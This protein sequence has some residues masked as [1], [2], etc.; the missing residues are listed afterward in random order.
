MDKLILGDGLLGS[1]LVKQTNWDYISR[2]KDKIDFTSPKTYERK[3]QYPYE[4]DTIINCIAYTDTYDLDRDKH[5]NVNYKGVVD[6]VDYIVDKNIKLIYIS[7]DY[8]Y[9]NSKSNVSEFIDKFPFSKD[10]LSVDPAFPN[11]NSPEPDI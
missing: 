6:L 1:E 11:L 5:W 2:K 7:S 8:L 3:L 10:I 4:F 9:D